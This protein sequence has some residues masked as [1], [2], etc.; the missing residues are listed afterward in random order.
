M[1]LAD[2]IVAVASHLWG[3][4]N[5]RLS[6]ATELRFGSK[7]S[8]VI[9]LT[10]GTWFDHE[11][12]EGGGTV[13]LIQRE[14]GV[15]GRG[16]QFQWMRD[17]LGI[18]VDADEPAKV[19][20]SHAAAAA[21]DDAM[22]LVA[23]Y[24]YADENGEL[25]FEVQRLEGRG[26][27]TF[28]QRHLENGRWVRNMKGV[29]RVLY[30]LPELQED[31]A[32]GRTIFI[33]EGEKKVDRLRAVGVPATC[34]V[35]G[36]G[37]WLDEYTGALDGADVVILPDHDPQAKSKEGKLLFHADGRPKIP[38]IDHALMVA[39]K[40]HGR[41][42][43]VRIVELPGLG[44]KEDV[45]QWLER[46]GT[47]AELYRLVEASREYGV[48]DYASHF[49]AVPWHDIPKEAPADFY[50]VDGLLEEGE[51]AVIAG[52]SGSGK[53]FVAIGIALSV[54]LGRPW[55][56]REAK[57]GG[58][59]YHA[60]ESARGVRRKRI[61]AYCTANHISFDDKV[62]FVLLT[63]PLDLFSTDTHMHELIAE[64]LHWRKTFT[65]PLRLIVIDTFAAA[66]AGMN[67]NASEDVTKV[68][69]RCAQIQIE[70]GAA[71]LLVHHMNAAGE[72]IRGHTSIHA[73]IQTV[74]LCKKLGQHDEHNRDIRELSIEK[75]KDDEA[76]WHFRF[77]LPSVELG[78]APNGKPI[79]SCIVRP[80]AGATAGSFSAK[81]N[82]KV[83]LRALLDALSEHGMDPPQSLGL[84]RSK[85]VVD[86]KHVK[87]VFA[88]A[89]ALDE[90]DAN[91][92]A[93]KERKR[94]A[95]HRARL[96]LQ[97]GRVIATAEGFMWLTGRPVVGM[98]FAQSDLFEKPD[99]KRDNSGTIDLE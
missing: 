57:Q 25:L 27:K 53:S 10:K 82:E 77:V 76:K 17:E 92:A 56:D 50:L 7:G 80:A 18:D 95:L 64:A 84:P 42:E 86:Y 12:D 88:R 87:E 61:P 11:A 99:T 63:K 16:E 78:T 73:N 94:K 85:R 93:A 4:P 33:V 59:I 49:G 45:V 71:V 44:A 83:F 54:A 2:H 36:A 28:V 6:T 46:G 3:E 35:G 89:T 41:A 14:T 62:P 23:T 1:K 66:T 22:R 81:D 58:V 91:T 72:K 21:I 20:G 55:M 48:A 38:G 60:G 19:N 65:V 51:A 67:E 39:E 9:D 24:P 29:R 52:P 32:L 90:D 98:S 43:R 30:R 34:N 79:T 13:D 15:V 70:T 68:L 5:V 31:V 69:S 8:R 75:Q 26:G 74:I 96:P 47:D 40:L 97:E 37:K